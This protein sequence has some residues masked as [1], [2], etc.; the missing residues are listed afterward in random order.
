MEDHAWR[1]SSDSS[2]MY[3]VQL[4]G[5]PDALNK[6]GGGVFEIVGITFFDT[7]DHRRSAIFVQAIRDLGGDVQ[8]ML[9]KSVIHELGHARAKLT[10]LCYF[11]EED[12]TWYQSS[13]HDDPACVMG[14]A[15]IAPC[16]GYDLT[17]DPHFCPACCNRLKRVNW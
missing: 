17:V 9:E 7:A 11:N 5:M 6:P 15:R 13:D 8:G 2:F 4:L 10:H 1:Y 14:Q 12:S 3:K 16:T